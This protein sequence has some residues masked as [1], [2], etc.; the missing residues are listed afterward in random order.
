[1][2]RR[3]TDDEY[4]ILTICERNGWTYAQWYA[5]SEDEQIDRLALLRRRHTFLETILSGFEK[6]IADEIPIEQ[7]AYINTLIERYIS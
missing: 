2:L 4:N 1:M 7:T 3:F 5:L 6:R